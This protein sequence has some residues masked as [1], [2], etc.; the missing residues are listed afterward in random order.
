MTPRLTSPWS[1]LICWLNSL[2]SMHRKSSPGSRMPHLVAMARA[3]LM[4][5]P[6]TMRTVMPA[7]WHLEMASGTWRGERSGLCDIE[8]AGGV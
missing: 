3:V 6:V 5:S 4:L 2:P 7:R 8:A 1:F